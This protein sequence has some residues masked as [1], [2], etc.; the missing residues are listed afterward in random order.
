MERLHQ[1]HPGSERGD[2]LHAYHQRLTD[3]DLRVHMAAARCW[4]I[5]EGSCSTLLPSPETVDYFAGDTV[6]LGLA[7]IEAHYFVNNIFLP[8][9]SLLKNVEKLRGI[10]AAIVH[11]RYDTVCPIVSADDLHRAWPEA[12]YV[13]VPDAGHSAWGRAS[14][15][16]GTGHGALQAARA[17]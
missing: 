1:A 10:P 6:A 14:V 16:P 9:N 8:E 3:P 11:G 17:S 5:Y 7:R 13:I 15:R 4:S 12:E 2:L